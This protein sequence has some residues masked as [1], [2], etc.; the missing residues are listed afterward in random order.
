MGK[1]KKTG[2]ELS[3][4]TVDGR[5]FVQRRLVLGQLEQ[6]VERLQNVEWPAF[7]N[8]NFA[9]ICRA[10]GGDL[11]LALAIVLTEKGKKPQEKDIDALAEDLRFS[12]PL[13]EGLRAFKDF[14]TL[15]PT[16]SIAESLRDLAMTQAAIRAAATGSQTSS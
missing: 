2:E 6:L 10:I 15:N 12:L 7:D 3:Y 8:F 16:A 11:P 5:E 13:D 4:L 14:F 1:K 9:A